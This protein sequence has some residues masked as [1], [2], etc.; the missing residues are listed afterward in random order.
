MFRFSVAF[1]LPGTG[2]GI[3]AYIYTDR[4]CASG[5]VC[6]RYMLYSCRNCMIYMACE[7]V[8]MYKFIRYN[9]QKILFYKTGVLQN[10]GEYGILFSQASVD[11]KPCLDTDGGGIYS[12]GVHSRGILAWV[13]W[14][15]EQREG[16]QYAYAEWC[17]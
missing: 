7:I 12:C 1:L 17:S 15:M 9:T 6:V 10:S 2:F 14:W 4:S 11:H 5:K 8:K 16:W 13:P 3:V